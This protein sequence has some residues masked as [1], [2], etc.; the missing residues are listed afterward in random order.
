MVASTDGK[1][2]IRRE[3]SGSVDSP[4]DVG[5]SVA[6]ALMDAGAKEIL[7]T[8]RANAGLG[9]VGAA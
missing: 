9:Q 6:N 7:E 3:A 2:V 8:A 4:E 1:T 5:L